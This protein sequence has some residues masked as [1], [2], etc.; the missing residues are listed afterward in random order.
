MEALELAAAERLPGGLRRATLEQID[1]CEMPDLEASTR[2]RLDRI[3]RDEEILWAEGYDLGSSRTMQVP[4]S[5]VGVDY[6]DRPDGFHTAFQVSTD[7]LASGFRDDEAIL[8]G[9]CELIERDAIALMTFMPAE[10][11]ETRAYALDDEDGPDVAAMRTAI[12][13]V[14]CALNVIDMTSD[15]GVP[16]FT[17]IIS[18]PVGDADHITQYAHSGGSGC[19]PL[20][21]RA[22]EKAIVEAAQSRITRITG[23]RDDLPASTYGAAE[24]EDRRA[25]ADM[26]SFAR[27]G[28]QRRR[29]SCP[30]GDTPEE[31]IAILLER[32]KERGIEQAVVVPIANDFEIAVLRV[33][34]PGLQTELTGQR[35]K[36]GRRALMKLVSRL[37]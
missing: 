8:H 17:A 5:L 26:L 11:L 34:V 36:L 22:L 9:L 2:C 16:A 14:G 27:L 33:I 35:S 15:I 4:W 29:P 20:C 10:E 28:A 37:Q 23:S 12:E 13:A 6:R 21:Q 24:G 1:R 7:G 18:D 25:A 31:N 3:R 19:H 30:S 32:L